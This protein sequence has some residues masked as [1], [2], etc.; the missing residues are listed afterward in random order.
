V[1]VS[2]QRRAKFLFR[3]SRHAGA[4]LLRNTRKTERGAKQFLIPLEV[5]AAPFALLR[6]TRKTERGTGVL[7]TD[8]EVRAAPFALLRNLYCDAGLSIS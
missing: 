6:N 8:L 5:R 2:P 3:W 1:S 4:P 7:L